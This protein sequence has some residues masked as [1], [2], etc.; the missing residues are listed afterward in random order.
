MALG[1]D[2]ILTLAAIDLKIPVLAAIPF[3][4]QESK[5]PES[6]QRLYF[7]LLSNPLVEK[8]ICAPGG[9]NNHKFDHRNRKMCDRATE[10]LACFWG[11]AGGTWNTVR[12]AV[13]IGLPITR[14]PRYEPATPI[15]KKD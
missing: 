2:T 4:G 7:K 5:W 6:S 9:W 1:F 12:Y 8:W 14:I 15:Q 3:E 10:L 13:E 11:G